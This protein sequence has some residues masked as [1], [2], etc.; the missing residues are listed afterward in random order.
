MSNELSITLAAH[1]RALVLR[2]SGQLDIEGAPILKQA[3][4]HV[5]PDV[6]TI[7]IDLSEVTF[8]DSTALSVL[9]G[10]Q[11][12]L[13]P[14]AVLRLRN[15]T[16]AARR[17]IDLTGLDRTFQIDDEQT[18]LGRPL[19]VWRS[20]PQADVVAHDGAVGTVVRGD[21]GPCQL[22]EDAA[23]VVGLVAT[24]MPFAAGPVDQAER[25]LR[26][27]CRNGDAGFVLEAAGVGEPTGDLEIP[28][29]S[30]ARPALPPGADPVEA[31]T[32][33]AN[34]AV[35]SRGEVMTRSSD[36]LAAV[37]DLYGDL[38]TEALR[39]H[40]SNPEEA[41]ERLGQLLGGR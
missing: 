40:S 29:T 41:L 11:Q 13:D 16:D 37:R 38:F 33:F 31:V 22:S 7:V 8:I 20:Q 5:D 35:R 23:T 25:W 3:L 30:S 12:Q 6:R 1:D 36:L 9:I 10:F 27:L 24:A 39:R 28:L 32:A 14:P 18:P 34:R 4:Q 21:P 2:P 19:V 26:A 17:L 15:L